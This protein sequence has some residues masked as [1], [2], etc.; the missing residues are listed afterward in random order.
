MWTSS[1]AIPGRTAASKTNSGS[2][3]DIAGNESVSDSSAESEGGSSSHLSYGISRTP[4]PS[5]KKRRVTGN[6]ATKACHRVKKQGQLGLRDWSDV[7]GVASMV[8]WEPEAVG[9]AAA[10]C[11]TLFGEGISFRTLAEEE[12]FLGDGRIVEYRPDMVSP[13]VIDGKHVEAR[14]KGA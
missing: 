10:R 11:S 9:R 2:S 12:T 5:V 6:P 1:P 14:P 13:P 7:L 3:L 8:G 4:P